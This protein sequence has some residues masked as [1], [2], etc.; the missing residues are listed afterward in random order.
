MLDIANKN[1]KLFLM[2]YIMIVKIHDIKLAI[3]QKWEKG[4]KK[5]G[6]SGKLQFFHVLTIRI[7]TDL[8][9]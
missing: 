5:S 2:F 7:Q 6:K 4:R 9:L 1:L 8:I 3:E